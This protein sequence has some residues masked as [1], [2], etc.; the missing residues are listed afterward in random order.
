VSPNVT[1]ERGLRRIVT[2]LSVALLGVGLT[3]DALSILP[4]ATVEVT[5]NDGRKFTLQ[6]HE[7]RA[8]LADRN[9]LTSALPEEASGPPLLAYDAEALR[10]FRAAYP[11]Y[12]D[13]PDLD[14]ARRIRD[15]PELNSKWRVTQGEIRLD[16]EI[17]GV[18]VLHGPRYW[19]WTDGEWT[20]AAA[21]LVAFLWIVFYTVRW[22]VRGF[23]GS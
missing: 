18:R 2:V 19:W 17:V 1:V 15:K 20:K 21:A 11:Q 9:S 22:I 6:R 5:L 14:L 10:K 23:T 13:I 7:P 4:H 3:L 16:P 12:R 8:L